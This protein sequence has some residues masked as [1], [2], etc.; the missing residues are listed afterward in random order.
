MSRGNSS[1]GFKYVC[2]EEYLLT[3]SHRVFVYSMDLL[4][5]ESCQVHV[6]QSVDLYDLR[7][8]SW[9]VWVLWQ[10]Y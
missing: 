9:E 2:E 6:C 5:L 4:G 8:I 3:L 1:L 10:G 7:L